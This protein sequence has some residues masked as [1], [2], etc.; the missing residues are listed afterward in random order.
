MTPKSIVVKTFMISA[1]HREMRSNNAFE[2]PCSVG[3]PRLS[4]AD[5]TWSAAQL[6]R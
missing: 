1:S 6:G 4:A 2:R 3:G 5:A